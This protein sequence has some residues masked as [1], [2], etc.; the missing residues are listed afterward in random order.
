MIHVVT[1]H[2]SVPESAGRS[3]PGYVCRYRQC[4][5][6]STP[7]GADPIQGGWRRSTSESKLS[8][9][10][11]KEASKEPRSWEPTHRITIGWLTRVRV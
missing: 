10:R 4:R 9:A 3:T 2:T 1:P 11:W 5:H 6:S 7:T 8:K